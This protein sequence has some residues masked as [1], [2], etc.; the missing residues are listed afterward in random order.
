MVQKVL[1]AHLCKQMQILLLQCKRQKPIDRRRF[2][3][4]YSRQDTCS[5]RQIILRRPV[6]VRWS[7]LRLSPGSVPA[8]AA[9]E[10][11]VHNIQI[12]FL[13]R[14]TPAHAAG[15]QLRLK[16]HFTGELKFKS[17]FQLLQGEVSRR[18]GRV[19]TTEELKTLLSLRDYLKLPPEVISMALTF[20]LQ[21][22]EYYNKSAGRNRTMSMRILEKECYK[23]ANNGIQTLE[24]ASAYISHSLE[25]LAPEAQVKKA[26]G[27][28][29]ALVD[30]EREYIHA[31]LN[32]GFDVDAIRQAYEKTVLATGKL[33]WRYM[34]KILLNWHEKNLHSGRQV[35]A[36]ERKPQASQSTGGFTPGAGEKAAVS[37]LQRFRES[38]K[39]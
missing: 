38:L 29:R 36:E 13:C 23:W 17:G 34:N 5:E 6:A 14:L 25:L 2:Q 37:N 28:D 19:L 7:T 33:A 26:M 27:L 1:F 4:P 30:S 22:L 15:F 20:C 18:M 3:I 39:E 16:P 35:S 31:W 9:Q 8:G 11:S 32:M 21:R 12:D 24:Q 10:P